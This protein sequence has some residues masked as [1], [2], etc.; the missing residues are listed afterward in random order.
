MNSNAPASVGDTLTVALNFSHVPTADD[1]V[2]ST[3]SAVNPIASLRR[4]IKRG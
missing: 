2:A 3:V 4:T 1:P